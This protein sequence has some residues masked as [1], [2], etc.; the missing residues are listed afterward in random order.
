MVLRHRAVFMPRC[1]GVTTRVQR[2]GNRPIRRCRG[3]AAIVRG[4]MI[5]RVRPSRLV[6]VRLPYPGERL[7]VEL[8]NLDGLLPNADPVLDQ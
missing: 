3:H 7:L 8:P 6:L 4:R 5:A 2:R 1:G